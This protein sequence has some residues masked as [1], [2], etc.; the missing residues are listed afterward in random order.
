[1]KL[2]EDTLR[3]Q[4]QEAESEIAKF[5]N[6]VK[7]KFSPNSYSYGRSE[8]L[9]NRSIDQFLAKRS[10]ECLF[11]IPKPLPH[12]TNSSTTDAETCVCSCSVNVTWVIK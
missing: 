5:A 12:L 11:E 3:K 2:E 6:D 8:M 1:M 4:Q 10:G 9:L 7:N